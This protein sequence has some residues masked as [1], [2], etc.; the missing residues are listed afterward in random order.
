MTKRS[1]IP[2][3][4]RVGNIDGLYGKVAPSPRPAHLINPSAPRNPP[5]ADPTA[6]VPPPLGKPPLAGGAAAPASPGKSKSAEVKAAA[7][8]G[9]T[10]RA[11]TEPDAPFRS[12]PEG[13]TDAAKISRSSKAVAAGAPKVFP[14]ASRSTVD[15]GTKKPATAVPAKAGRVGTEIGLPAAKRPIRKPPTLAI[16]PAVRPD[17]DGAVATSAEAAD[18]E[19]RGPDNEV[20]YK[21]PPSQHRFQKGRSGNPKGRPK[22]AKSFK[23]LL[24]SVLNEKVTVNENGVTT[25]MTKLE[26]IARRT[27]NEAI[28]GNPKPI[29]MILAVEPEDDEGASGAPELSAEEQAFLEGYLEQIFASQKKAS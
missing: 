12:S 10:P 19:G 3:P 2:L 14:L 24:I 20:G 29:P 25:K 23:K 21:K 15:V 16:R 13:D 8:A 18:G 6:A 7:P 4:S 22:G 28:K 27:V 5:P 1:Y 26:V 9:A 17:A 11:K